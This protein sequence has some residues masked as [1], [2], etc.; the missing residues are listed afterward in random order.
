MAS[1]GAGYLSAHLQG[2]KQ[3]LQPLPKVAALSPRVTTVLGMNPAPYSLQGTNCY[4]IGTGSERLLLDTG[5]GKTEFHENLQALLK[6]L[7]C[8]ISGILLTHSHV[9]HLGG[10]PQVLQS[11]P[12]A[13][14]W[15]CHP[16]AGLPFG[17]LGTAEDAVNPAAVLDSCGASGTRFLRDGDVVATAGATLRAVHT[18]GHAS[19]HLCFWLQEERALFTGDVILGVGTVIID[20][21]EEYTASLQRLKELAPDRIYPG[22]GPMLEG[23][24]AR[25]RPGDYLRHRW[26]RLEAARALLN[27]RPGAW[28]TDQL[29]RGVYGASLP[30]DAFLHHAARRN[31]EASLAQLQATGAAVQLGTASWSQPPKKAGPQ[32]PQKDISLQQLLRLARPKWGAK[33]LEA[34]AAKLDAVGC[35]A[36]LR[37]E[38][39]EGIKLCKNIPLDSMQHAWEP[40]PSLEVRSAAATASTPPLREDASTGTKEVRRRSSFTRT[41]G[42]NEYIQV[43]V[44]IRPFLKRNEGER[45][46]LSVDP[47]NQVTLESKGAERKSSGV[48]ESPLQGSRDAGTRTF[49]FDF[50]LDSRG[51]P[52][53]AKFA[54][55]ETPPRLVVCER[56]WK[57][58]RDNPKVLAELIEKELSEG[59]LEE[60]SLESAQQRWDNVAVARMN[61]DVRA[62]FPL[63]METEAQKFEDDAN[64]KN[65]QRRRSAAKANDWAHELEDHHAQKNDRDKFWHCARCLWTAKRQVV[66]ICLGAKKEG[67]LC[68]ISDIGHVRANGKNSHMNALVCLST[69]RMSL[70]SP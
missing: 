24:A 46:T 6:S 17:R 11:F 31:L 10:L 34:A 66:Q 22:H 7:G 67:S 57:G 21:F 14:V 15:R 35:F 55:Q 52:G 53:D 56:N 37:M 64:A 51:E 2:G 16:A 33:D 48:T 47:D 59:F 32:D 60:L 9:D 19:D 49:K 18:P 27:S 40:F 38:V 63:R 45:N 1:A 68:M 43:A 25:E 8:Q 69:F 3:Q 30:T 23:A 39:G 50:V 65:V 58:A 4:L 29:L 20:S 70:T 42:D 28:T 26:E 5:E 36:R 54:S 44:R 12:T 41:P 62:A 13:P 61:A